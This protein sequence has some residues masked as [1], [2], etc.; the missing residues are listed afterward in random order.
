MHVCVCLLFLPGV[1][2]FMYMEGGTGLLQATAP[3]RD[4]LFGIVDTPNSYF[5]RCG[6]PPLIPLHLLGG[7]RQDRQADC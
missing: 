2:V 3:S 1:C 6:R 7:C 4:K 5:F